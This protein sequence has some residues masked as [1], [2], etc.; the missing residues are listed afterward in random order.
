MVQE[1]ISLPLHLVL[2]PVLVES[3]G[4]P[5]GLLGCLLLSEEVSVDGVVVLEDVLGNLVLH[6]R[7]VGHLVLRAGF[8]HG[9]GVGDLEQPSRL[10]HLHLAVVVRDVLRNQEVYVAHWQV[11]RTWA[12][13]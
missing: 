6:G 12:V 7:G 3:I 5:V 9:L 4:N 8:F 10:L 2:P 13:G 11:L 1:C